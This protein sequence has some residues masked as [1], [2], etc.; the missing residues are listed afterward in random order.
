MLQSFC[1]FLLTR[2][3][4]WTAEVTVPA[5]DKCLICVAPH[6]SNKDFL[7]GELYIRSIGQQAGFLM[8]KR[9]V[10]LAASVLFF[11]ASVASLWN[12][13]AILR[14]RINSVSWLNPQI[15][16]LAVTP[17]G[18]RQRVETWKRGFYYTR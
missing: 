6:T 17:E 18:T 10:L 16:H 7:L 13:R 15:F 14:S 1:H 11:G 9:M 12:A 8:K 4:G 3:L 5:R 2:V